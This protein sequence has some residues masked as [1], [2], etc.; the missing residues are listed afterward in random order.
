M[1]VLSIADEILYKYCYRTVYREKIIEG[2]RGLRT[3]SFM[4]I[5][6][7]N[8]VG[9]CLLISFLQISNLRFNEANIYDFFPFISINDT[10]FRHVDMEIFLLIEN[11][12]TL[13]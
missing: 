12:Y 2:L 10:I 7:T 6:N 3:D 1:Y 11:Q 8:L 5:D 13:I 4:H 9:H